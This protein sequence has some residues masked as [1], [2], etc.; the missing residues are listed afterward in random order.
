MGRQVALEHGAGRTTAPRAFHSHPPPELSANS[1]LFKLQ[2]SPR[3]QCLGMLST[4]T[5]AAAARAATTATTT[6][7]TTTTRPRPR[8]LYC[9]RGVS[10]PACNTCVK[11]FAEFIA[12]G[13]ALA[14]VPRVYRAETACVGHDLQTLFF[15]E[16]SERT[17]THGSPE[18]LS[19]GRDLLLLTCYETRTRNASHARLRGTSR[20]ETI[21]RP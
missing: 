12:V 14:R 9:S 5:P 4:T 2:P 1:G 20:A 17:E 21:L 3:P 8:P 11:L 6:A 18:T 10:A 16:V 7:A 15:S 19:A 13:V